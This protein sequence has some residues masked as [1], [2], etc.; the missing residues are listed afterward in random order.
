[1]IILVENHHIFLILEHDPS[2]ED[3]KEM[4]STGDPRP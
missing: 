1:M 3:A 2:Y 4:W